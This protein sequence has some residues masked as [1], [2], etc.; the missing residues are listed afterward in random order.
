[1]A[2]VDK[3]L[4]LTKRL[5]PKGRAFNIRVNSNRER[6][7]K[8]LDV[9]EAT[10]YND[11]LSILD[12]ILPDND[13]FTD[14]DATRWEQRL[15]MIDGSN[16]T[17]ANRKLAIARKMNH[18][19]TIPARQSIDYIE[20]QLQ[21]AG[22]NVFA[23]RSN[24]MGIVQVL[25]SAGNV[26]QLGSTQLGQS[27]LGGVYGY[28][29]QY[30]TCAQLGASQLGQTQLNSCWYN[31]NLINNIDEALDANIYITNQFEWLFYIGGPT[32]GSFANVDASRKNEFRQLL[33]K[34]KPVNSAAHLLID[35]V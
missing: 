34:L 30:F 35:Y 6:L 10:A 7:H 13:N 11:A 5:Y 23:Y 16:T 15:G 18:P 8:A 20:Q 32:L 31:N 27:Q 26:P 3:I 19:G 2:V 24:G 28:Y 29:A 14:E 22:F 12:A 1:M 21:D 25:S 17:L 9:S 33:L 4:A